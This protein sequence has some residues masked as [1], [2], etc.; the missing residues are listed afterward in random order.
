MPYSRASAAV[1]SVSPF[2]RVIAEQAAAFDEQGFFVL[3]DAVDPATIAALTD[4]IEPFD[5]EVMDF[6][7]TRPDGR[8]SIAGVR[9]RGTT[10][11]VRVPIV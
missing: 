10:V 6:L 1:R 4:A 3:E 2:R 11:T 9:G 8:F 5:R 7:A